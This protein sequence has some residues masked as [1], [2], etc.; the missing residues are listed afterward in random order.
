MEEP[1]LVMHVRAYMSLEP[2]GQA[3]PVNVDK[4]ILEG[5]GTVRVLR[6]SHTLRG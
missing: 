1:L 6:R 4:W 5:P 2:R 3:E